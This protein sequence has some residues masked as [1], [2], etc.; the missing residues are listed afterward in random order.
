MP[1]LTSVQTK[2]ALLD[3]YC[4]ALLS[5]AVSRRS[6]INQGKVLCFDCHATD[7]H[8][9]TVVIFRQMLPSRHD[10]EL[11]V[12]GGSSPA[13]DDAMPP[14]SSLYASPDREVS[15]IGRTSLYATRAGTL[16]RGV[17]GRLWTAA[18]VQGPR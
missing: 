15:R 10:G 1:G 8:T 9:V 12:D 17:R 7:P 2:I 5:N 18:R 6:S 13:F 14:F 4:H 3:E 11:S 16:P